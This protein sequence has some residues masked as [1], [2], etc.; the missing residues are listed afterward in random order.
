MLSKIM[1]SFSLAVAVMCA[2]MALRLDGSETMVYWCGMNV[3]TA[4]LWFATCKK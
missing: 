3:F 1:C 4:G 2:L